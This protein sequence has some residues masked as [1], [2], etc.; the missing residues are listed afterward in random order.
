MQPPE[1]IVW[2]LTKPID[3]QLTS[4]LTFAWAVQLPPQLAM[5][6]AW[7]DAVGG[8]P[9]HCPLQC[10]PQLALQEASHCAELAF[11]AQEPWQFPEQSASHD[12]WQSKLPGFAVQLA[13]QLP[14]QLAVQFTSADALHIPMQP[15]SSCAAQ[16]AWKLIGVHWVVQ[17]PE[18]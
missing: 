10:P 9:M 8:V 12:P 17:P 4:Q 14:L 16:A 6:L 5:H 18:V 2:Q 1:S 13:M 3:W 7:H 11:D 15:T